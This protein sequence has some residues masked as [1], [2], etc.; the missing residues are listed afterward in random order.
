[1]NFPSSSKTMFS[2]TVTCSQ[3]SRSAESTSKPWKS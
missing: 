1:M 3:S 2:G